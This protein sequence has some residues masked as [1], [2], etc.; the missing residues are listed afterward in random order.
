M[1]VFSSNITIFKQFS[2]EIDFK[3]SLARANIFFSKT[4]RYVARAKNLGQISMLESARI[5]SEY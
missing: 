5:V 4:R 1:S 3:N 2:L